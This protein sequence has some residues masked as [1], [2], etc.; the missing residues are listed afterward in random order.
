MRFLKKRTTIPIPAVHAYSSSLDNILHCPFILMDF[1]EGISAYDCWLNKSLSTD[2]LAACR[3]QCLKDI[4]SAMVQLGRF[5][6]EQGGSLLFDEELNPVG[7]GSYRVVDDLAMLDRAFNNDNDD[8]GGNGSGSSSVGP[9]GDEEAE[10]VRDKYPWTGGCR[11][12]CE[13]EQELKQEDE[14]EHER[15]QNHLLQHGEESD[16]LF[17]IYVEAGPVSKTTNF[18]TFMLDRKRETDGN[19]DVGLRSL[20]RLFVDWLPEPDDEAAKK[21]PFV[22]TH[23]DFNFQNAIVSHDGRLQGLI[24]WDGVI[25]VPR[26]IGNELY[27]SWLTR[28]WDPGRYGYTSDMEKG[29]EPDGVWEDSP[30]TSAYYRSVYEGYMSSAIRRERSGVSDNSAEQSHNVANSPT[31]TSR[32][33]IA[34]NLYCAVHDPIS[35]DAIVLKIFDEL[36]KRIKSAS[37]RSEEQVPATTDVC[38]GACAL[39]LSNMTTRL[40]MTMM[41]TVLI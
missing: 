20:L 18:Y 16:D 2:K 26:S 1:V 7:T 37:C 41:L 38:D 11:R 8:D 5:T 29:I 31:T 33:L 23:P 36:A 6:F 9:G 40:R 14:L 32:S 30:E 25:A 13:E 39:F 34:F 12:E 22:L 3:K 10:E 4:A 15:G 17:A 19:F 24:D 27:P 21:K 35:T 28:D